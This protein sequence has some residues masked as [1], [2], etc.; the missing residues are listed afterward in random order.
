MNATYAD[1]QNIRRPRVQGAWYLNELLP[2][3]DFFVILSSLLGSYGNVGQAIYAG[4]SVSISSPMSPCPLSSLFP[5]QLEHKTHALS[6][7]ILRRIRRLPTL[8]WSCCKP[9]CLAHSFG[10]GF[11]GRPQPDRRVE[12]HS[13]SM[14]VVAPFAGTNTRFHHGALLGPNVQRQVRLV[15]SRDWSQYRHVGLAV[16]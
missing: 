5:L 8:S 2:N 13:R 9:Y 11:C 3:L 10:R 1:W 7:D 12:G 16:L 14:P 4:T 15:S 6:V